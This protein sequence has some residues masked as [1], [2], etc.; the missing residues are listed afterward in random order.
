MLLRPP[1]VDDA[2]HA[3]VD[4]RARTDFRQVPDVVGP[5]GRWY[6]AQGRPTCA[7]WRDVWRHIGQ[8]RRSQLLDYARALNRLEDLELL[9]EWDAVRIDAASIKSDA[10]GPASRRFRSARGGA[11]ASRTARLGRIPRP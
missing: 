6:G 3:A 1:Q 4:E 8:S 9:A 2:A 5:E 11:V 10:A 7:R